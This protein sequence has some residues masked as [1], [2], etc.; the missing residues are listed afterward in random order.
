MKIDGTEKTLQADGNGPISAFVNAVH[1]LEGVSFSIDDY[2]EQAA[3]KGAEATAIAYVPLKLGSGKIVYGVGKD[4][5]IDQAA[6]HAI[7]AALNRV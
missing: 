6:V 5:N 3:G 2:D 4:T 7:V 1:Q